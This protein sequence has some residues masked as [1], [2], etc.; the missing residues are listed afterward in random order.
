MNFCGPM[1][2]LFPSKNGRMSRDQNIF[3]VSPALHQLQIGFKYGLLA[4]A[5]CNFH[6]SVPQVENTFYS[7][8]THFFENLC[9]QLTISKPRKKE[10][11]PRTLLFYYFPTLALFSIVSTGQQTCYTHTIYPI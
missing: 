2:V 3:K 4:R 11:C 10:I 7:Q 5:M 6:L 8:K 9:L 1:T